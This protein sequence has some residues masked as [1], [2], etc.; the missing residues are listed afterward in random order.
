MHYS[1]IIFFILFFQFSWSQL[2]LN[3]SIGGDSFLNSAR[4]SAMGETNSTSMRTSG[5]ILKNP[6]G[7]LRLPAGT[8]LDISAGTNSTLER[9]SILVKDFFGD[10]L[11]MG[12]YVATRSSYSYF[13]GGLITRNNSENVLTAFSFMYS[14]LTTFNYSYSE[15]VRG[16]LSIEDGEIDSKDPLAGYHTL[17]TSG[18]LELYSFG[19]AIGLKDNPSLHLGF[20]LHMPSPSVFR[21]KIRVDSLFTTEDL[22][23]LSSVEEYDTSYVLPEEFSNDNSFLTLSIDMDITPTIRL[24]ISAETLLKLVTDSSFINP[25]D[26][27]YGLPSLTSM[28]SET[29]N[30]F[31]TPK[32]I[33]YVKPEKL[34][35]GFQYTPQST[36]PSTLSF[37][38][39]QVRYSRL[40]VTNVEVKNIN[41]LKIGFEYLALNSIPVRAGIIF[42]EMPLE[43]LDP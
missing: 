7:M 41:I 27:T 15:E 32:C 40:K 13:Q 36:M 42:K 30:V 35:I 39:E 10:F 23:N 3:R 8:Q 11:T 21:D 43:V 26:S 1:R 33:H 9:R 6:A 37:E 29:G 2:F 5:L 4:S 25:G 34:R 18:S 16:E 38:W 14:P 24:N 20:G 12:D 31:F 22:S 17:Q 28:D 19:F